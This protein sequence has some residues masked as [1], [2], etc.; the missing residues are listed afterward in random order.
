MTKALIDKTRVQK[1]RCFVSALFIKRW[2]CSV[3][4]HACSVAVHAC[5]VAVHEVCI[6][7]LSNQKLNHLTLKIEEL[8]LTLICWLLINFL[9][10]LDR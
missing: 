7:I 1:N 2:S 10:V 4:V 5:S 3:A 9:Y 6:I 8:D